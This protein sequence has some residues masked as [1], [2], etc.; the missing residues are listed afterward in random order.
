MRCAVTDIGSN[1]IKMNI[2]DM[3]ESDFEIILSE[4]KTVGLISYV[5]SG[6][7]SEDG[8]L[9]LVETLADFK[10]LS[11]KVNCGYFA[12]LATAS[13]RCVE[14][15]EDVIRIVRERAGVDIDM[16]SGEREAMFSFS[17]LKCGLKRDIRSGI[18]IDMGGGSTELL[19]FIDDMAVRAESYPF[20][21]LSLYKQFVKGIFPDKDERRAIRKFVDSKIS[22]VSWL[23]NYGDTVYLVGG[24]GRAIGR[25]HKVMYKSDGVCIDF[26]EFSEMT[27]Y[28]KSQKRDVLDIMIKNVPDRLHTVIPGMIAY[29][30]LFDYIGAKNIIVTDFGLREGYLMEVMS[31]K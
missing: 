28:F 8:I 31:K 6:V 5:S 11:A 10:K 3:A 12:A 26:C 18:M 14:N 15:V 23:D 24:T 4:S 27:K 30:K 7:M 16:I 17:G 20:G 19:S 2:Y 29:R 25:L 21:C 13:L 22:N 1:T 9:K